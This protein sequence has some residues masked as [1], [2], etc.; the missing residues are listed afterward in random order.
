MFLALQVWL[1]Y[2][3]NANTVFHVDNMSVVFILQNHTSTD[4]VI[5][6]MI[7]RMVVLSML[8]NV[9]FTSKHV[10]GKHNLIAD[11]LSRFQVSVAREWAP[12]L[13]TD[14]VVVPQDSY[15]WH[16]K[17]LQPF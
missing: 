16:H 3:S 1:P 11:R 12:W 4:K 17:P 13:A 5:M 10:P 9:V 7:R 8:H 2:F 15:P 14:P 6:Q